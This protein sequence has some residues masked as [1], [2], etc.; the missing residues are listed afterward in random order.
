LRHIALYQQPGKK[1]SFATETRLQAVKNV[2][3]QNAPVRRR[4]D[5]GGE[6]IFSL[7]PGDVLARK[8]PDG[9]VEY[10]VVRKF[11][12]AGRVF[13]K[14]VTQA[15]TPKPE[16]SFG[17]ASFADGTLTKVSVDPIGRVRPARD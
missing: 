10:I 17:P 12:Q 11:N 16:V 3:E 1:I 6:L 14:P 7:C 2:R 13:Y 8:T 9:H 15:G 5:N 4:L